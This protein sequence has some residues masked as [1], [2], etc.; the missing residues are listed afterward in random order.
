MRP[1]LS[2]VFAA[3]NGFANTFAVFCFDVRMGNGVL[4]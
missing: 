2:V 3:L 4:W 1:G